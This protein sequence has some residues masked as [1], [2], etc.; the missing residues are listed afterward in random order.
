MRISTALVA[1]CLGVAG[2]GYH[3][4]YGQRATSVS[5]EDLA[6]VYVSGIPDRPGQVLRNDL[7]QRLNPNGQATRPVDTLTVGLSVASTGVSLSRDNTTSRTSI[8]TT[9][10]YTLVDSATGKALFSGTSRATDAYDVLIS[11][12]ATLVSRDD[13]VDRAIR[14]VSDDIRTRLAVYFQDRKIKTGVAGN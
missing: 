6:R 8:T 13:A 3:P 12:Y 5:S 4:L 11:D 1:L 2:C 14:E 9:A 7:I 10:K